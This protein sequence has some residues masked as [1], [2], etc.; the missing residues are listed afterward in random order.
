MARQEA[1]WTQC[2]QLGREY[3]D[4][5]PSPGRRE[6]ALYDVAV[7]LKKG[8]DPGWS[9]AVRQYMEQYPQGAHAGELRE[10]AR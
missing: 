3:L 4:G 8:G 10:L 5:S 7:C 9:E 6:Q 2:A 1:R